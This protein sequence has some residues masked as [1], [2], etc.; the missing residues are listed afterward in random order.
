MTFVRT[1][2]RSA[3]TLGMVVIGM[4]L[5]GHAATVVPEIDPSSGINAIALLAGALLVFRGRKR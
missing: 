4:G 5:S 3:V 2:S 1:W